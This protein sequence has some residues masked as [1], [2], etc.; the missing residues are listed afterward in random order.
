M[1]HS[2]LFK[3]ADGADHAA[4]ASGGKG[5]AGEAN[6]ENLV[7]RAVIV[8]HVVVD[9]KGVAPADVLGQTAGEAAAEDLFGDAPGAAADAGVIIDHLRVVL[10]ALGR[11]GPSE[12]SD[13]CWD[14]GMTMVKGV[15]GILFPAIVAVLEKR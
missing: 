2:R 6:Q 11:D 1:H 4:D 15:E 14:L 13:V 8:L 9:E 7:G 3:Q 10:L 12:A 5:T